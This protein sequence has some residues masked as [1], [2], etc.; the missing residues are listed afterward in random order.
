VGTQ[1]SEYCS[2]AG[3]DG[4]QVSSPRGRGRRPG[5]VGRTIQYTTDSP[6][7]RV[8]VVGVLVQHCRTTCGCCAHLG[9]ECRWLTHET[10]TTAVTPARA[11][12]SS[13]K[14][15]AWKTRDDRGGGDDTTRTRL[16]YRSSGTSALNR[17]PTAIVVSSSSSFVQVVGKRT[18]DDNR[19][20]G[21]R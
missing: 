5:D 15:T 6:M 8:V 21:G 20:N 4:V 16:V 19:R 9:A 7:C 2:S 3:N 17:R 11:T 14:K 12:R 10:T 18:G 1:R 13:D